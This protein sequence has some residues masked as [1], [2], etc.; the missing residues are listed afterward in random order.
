MYIPVTMSTTTTS[1]VEPRRSRRRQK[2]RHHHI[3][4]NVETLFAE[5]TSIRDQHRIA[6]QQHQSYWCQ[7]QV[8]SWAWC[9]V[10]YSPLQG[11]LQ[12]DTSMMMNPPY[13][14]HMVQESMQE[15]AIPEPCT[16]L[17]YPAPTTIEEALPVDIVCRR[18]IDVDTNIGCIAD[19]LRIIDIYDPE[20]DYN[21]DLAAMHSIR[22][23]L[24]QIND[25]VGMHSFKESL[26]DQ[27]LYFTQGLYLNSD[28]DYKHMVI[29]GPPGTGKTQLAKLVGKM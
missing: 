13:Q 25:M 19:L 3:T 21:I 10:P 28:S 29:Y 8:P 24:T 18:H 22:H 23:E 16:D 15:V 27:L 2:R 11:Q 6:A 14:P 12:C 1:M 4:P 26:V 20:V 7:H 9:Y 17:V 5:Y